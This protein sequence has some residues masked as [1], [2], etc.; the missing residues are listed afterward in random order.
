[1]H[2]LQRGGRERRGERGGEREEGR[3]RRGERGGEREEE[4]KLL[5]QRSHI[6]GYHFE[7]THD[8]LPRIWASRLSCIEG[9]QG[10]CSGLSSPLEPVRSILE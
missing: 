4:I 9:L 8:S 1:M 6:Q 5:E 7:V 10:C 3:E 2:E